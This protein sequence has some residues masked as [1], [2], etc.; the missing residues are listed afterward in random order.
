M[1][2]HDAL[3]AYR[4]VDQIFRLPIMAFAIEKSVAFAFQDIQHGSTGCF[5]RAASP[6]RRDFLLEYDHGANRRV[7]EGGMQEPL[8]FSL[9]IIF[10]GEIA[11]LNKP[12]ALALMLPLAIAQLIEPFEQVFFSVGVGDAH[13]LFRLADFIHR[14]LR[15]LFLAL[16][17]GWFSI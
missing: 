10:P 13:I 1:L 8:H 16:K 3:R 7:V 15:A 4:D 9:T 2:D 6:A 11:A 14:G 5:L 12:G 17:S